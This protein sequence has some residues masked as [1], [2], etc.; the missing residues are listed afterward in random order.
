MFLVATFAVTG[1]ISLL[2]W[3]AINAIGYVVFGGEL[4]FFLGMYLGIK[5][6]Y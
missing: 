1:G 2:V 5:S 4:V 6:E 3:G